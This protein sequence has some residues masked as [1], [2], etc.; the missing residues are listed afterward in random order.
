MQDKSRLEFLDSLR[1][2]AAFGIILFHAIAMNKLNYNGSGFLTAIHNNFGH[3]VPLF[4]ATSAFSLYLGYLY[5]LDSSIQIKDYFKKRFFRIAPLFYFMILVYTVAKY[6]KW[7]KV[8]TPFEYLI[9]ITFTFGLYPGKH[10]SIVWAGW[11]VGVEYLFYLILPILIIYIR[12]L[13]SA[14]FLFVLSLFLASY[15]DTIMHIN[16]GIAKNYIHMS[17][18]HQFPFFAAGIVAYMFYKQNQFIDKRKLG[19]FLLLIS[20][21]IYVLKDTVMFKFFYLTPEYV[22]ALL[23]I[24]LIVGLGYYSSRLIVN[25]ISVSLGKRSFS[26]YLLHPFVIGFMMPLHAKLFKTSYPIEVMYILVVLLTLIVLIPLSYITYKY[27]EVPFM[28]YA[29]KKKS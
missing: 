5:R 20:V 17:I 21:L 18:I 25:K 27:I 1:G 11:S 4:Y 23:F 2:L 6:I 10:Q 12:N 29:K 22:W 15:F 8:H 3:A 14:L 19:I 16:N 7:D 28:N 13:R 24:S 9:N 26:L